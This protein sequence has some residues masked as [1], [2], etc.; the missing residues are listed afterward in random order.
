[1]KKLLMLLFVSILLVACSNDEPKGE[2]KEDETKQAEKAEKKEKSEEKEDKTKSKPNMKEESEANAEEN[3][4]V[5][6][7]ILYDKNETQFKG[8]NYHFKGELVKV[9]KVEGLRNEAKDALLVKN[10]EGY[11]MPIFP[12]HE[13]EVSVGDEI[14]VWGPLSGDGYESIDLDVDNVVG[15]TGAM[16]AHIINVN[17]E[18]QN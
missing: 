17:D 10:D 14:E 8:M 6:A 18:T 1:M 11:V 13:V 2:K 3:P 12:P 7:A 15:I 4:A 9:R 5:M 16:N